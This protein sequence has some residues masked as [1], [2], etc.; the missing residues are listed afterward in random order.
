MENSV[1]LLFS[2]KCRQFD[3]QSETESFSSS[4]SNAHERISTKVMTRSAIVFTG[5]V[6][7]A[8]KSMLPGESAETRA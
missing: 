6:Y 4:Q 3:Y 2:T 5:P 7:G 1:Y 8:L